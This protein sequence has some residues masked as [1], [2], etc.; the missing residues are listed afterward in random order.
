MIPWRV[1]RHLN[2]TPNKSAPRQHRLVIGR[3]LHALDGAR[4]V[5]D[6]RP[7]TFTILIGPV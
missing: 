5:S 1:D 4:D 2:L 7:R 6:H 3:G